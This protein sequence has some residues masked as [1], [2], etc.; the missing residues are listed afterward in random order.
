LPASQPARKP[1]QAEN[2]EQALREV[3]ALVLSLAGVPAQVTIQQHK[4]RKPRS[5][6]MRC[7]ALIFCKLTV[8]L[9]PTT[10]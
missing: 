1:G 3:V 10:C 9:E 2:R 7:G 8:G 5:A 4:N 6:T